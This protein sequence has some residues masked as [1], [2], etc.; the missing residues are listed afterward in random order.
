MANEKYLGPKADIWSL[1]VIVYTLLAGEMPFQ[2]EN[3][4]EKLRCITMAEFDMPSFLSDEA[5]D[6]IHAVLQRDPEA[7]P[8]MEVG[9]QTEA[10]AKLMLLMLLARLCFTLAC[11]LLSTLLVHF[12]GVVCAPPP[13]HKTRQY[14][15]D[16]CPCHVLF[17]PSLMSPSS[18]VSLDVVQELWQHPWI[19]QKGKLEPLVLEPPPPSEAL[20]QQ[21]MDEIARETTFDLDDLRVAL[22]ENAT[23]RAPATYYLLLDRM[24]HD[25]K[26]AEKDSGTCVRIRRLHCPPHKKPCVCCL[27]ITHTHTRTH[28]HTHK[29]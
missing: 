9:G 27:F 15:H 18:L 11:S 28:T 26:Q 8:T 16:Q 2:A 4:A 21:C 12:K 29:P 20:V 14:L 24:M 22:R 7:R 13:F 17:P 23:T 25:A 1:G 19:S 6:L 5:Q 10:R 3:L